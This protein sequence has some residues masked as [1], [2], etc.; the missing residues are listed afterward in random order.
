MVRR[1][2]MNIRQS[3][4]DTIESAGMLDGNE[5]KLIRTIGGFWMA[6]CKLGKS[7]KETVLSAGSHPAIVKFNIQ[8]QYPQFQPAMYKSEAFLAE[9]TVE[10][11][12]HF[13]TEELIKSGY[14]IYS[15]QNVNSI[16]FHITKEGVKQ[17]EIKSV[18][19]N[20]ALFIPEL[21][22]DVVFSRALAGATLEKALSNGVKK[23]KIQK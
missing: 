8:K 14:E 17:S 6:I 2:K 7:L 1:S 23:I 16:D 13:L 19:S 10:S 5:V 4:I 11:H 3:D 22:T 21:K 18:I 9:P 12:S 15:L 20:E